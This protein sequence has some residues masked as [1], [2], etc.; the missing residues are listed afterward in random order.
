MLYLVTVSY[1]DK[2]LER[3][4]IFALMWSVGAVLELDDRA[5]LES[6]MLTTPVK[7]DWPKIKEGETIFEYVVDKNGTWQHWSERVEDFY[8]PPDQV[9]D[10]LQI[11]VPNVDNVRTG[12]LI[13]TIAKQGKAVLLIGLC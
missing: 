13:D 11:L 6:V 1:T 7:L 5:K 12:Y 9:L 3:F 10:Y 2:T 8:Y 4:F